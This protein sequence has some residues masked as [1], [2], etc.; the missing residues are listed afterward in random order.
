VPFVLRSIELVPPTTLSAKR[1]ALRVLLT[2][3]GAAVVAYSGGVDSSFLMACAH[4]ALGSAALAVTAISPSLPE[5]ARRDA[6][7]LAAQRGWQHELVLTH[8]VGREEYARNEADRCYWCKTELYEVLDPLARRRSATMLVGTNL[9][10][11]ADIRPGHRASRERG[12]RAPL[13]EAK[14]TKFD[15]RQLSRAIGLA[16]ADKPAG[17]CLASRFAY[18]VRVTEEGLRRIDRAEEHLRDLGFEELRVRDHGDLARI[19]VPAT[20]VARAAA[21][22]ASITAA[23]KDL[24]FRFVTLD[25]EGFRS[26]SLNDALPLPRIERGGRA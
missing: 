26:G 19:E 10:D 6:V 7:D 3:M 12:V 4:E 20:E 8:E 18:G 1:D 25:L 22:A 17:P 2:D 13:V 21:H 9:D 16:T 5:R 23:L 15:V 11:L 24:G 14:L